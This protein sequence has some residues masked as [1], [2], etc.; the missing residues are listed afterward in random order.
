MPIRPRGFAAALTLAL[1]AGPAAAAASGGF[2]EDAFFRPGREF[3]A[4]RYAASVTKCKERVAAECQRISR[5]LAKNMCAKA[6]ALQ[7]AAK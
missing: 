7:A 2:D 3:V 6:D 5:R 1:L 4:T